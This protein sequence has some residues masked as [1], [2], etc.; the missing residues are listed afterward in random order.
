ME[1]NWKYAN[2]RSSRAFKLWQDW[3]AQDKL[4]FL[5]QCKHDFSG[6]FRLFA[7]W[8]IE[9]IIGKE[10][11]ENDNESSL[12]IAKKVAKGKMKLPKL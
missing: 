10:Y 6:E 9:Q 12:H 5:N 7:T 3:D 4:A 1:Y 11:L 2:I 8:S